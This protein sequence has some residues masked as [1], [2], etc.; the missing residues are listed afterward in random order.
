M[1]IQRS[2]CLFIIYMFTFHFVSAVHMNTWLYAVVDYVSESFSCNNCS[3]A[4]CFPD[5]SS[6][7][8]NEQVCLGVS[9]GLI[10]HC[11]RMYFI[12]L[13]I[14]SNIIVLLL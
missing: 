7:C 8:W 9:E 3:M 1:D 11:I 6:W 14:D 10:P 5:K 13:F 2:G 4:E 12:Y